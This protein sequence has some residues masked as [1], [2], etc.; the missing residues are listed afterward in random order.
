[1]AP[2]TLRTEAG[3]AAR[4]HG[5]GGHARAAA[6][7]PTAVRRRR[8][9]WRSSPLAR[10]RRRRD[11]RRRRVPRARCG[12]RTAPATVALRLAAGR[13]TSP[14]TLRLA[15]PR[16]LGPAVARLRRLLDLDAD[17]VAVDE[18]ARAP[19]RRWPRPSPRCRAS[20]C[21][22][23]ST[24]SRRRCARVLGPAGVGR[25]GPHGGRAAGRGAGRAAAR[26]RSPA[27]GR[28]PAVPD[29]RR[30]SPSTAPRCSPA[31][32][33]GSRARARLGRGA[34][35][36]HAARSTPAAT[37]PTCAPSWSRCPASGR[38]P[39]ATSRC[40]CSATPTSCWP[41]DLARAPRRRRPRPAVRR[42][43]P[44]PRAAR[45]RPGGPSRHPPVAR[46]HAATH[47]WR[48]A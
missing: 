38:G 23:R 13:A 25:G 9:C 34:R 24:A 6:A 21:R 17:P 20:G 15:D 37:P 32:P 45:W 31:R 12:C 48:S 10:R 1:M 41:N 16:D 22:A 46:R 33:G 27:T 4:R 3:R 42:R 8:A 26:P 28:R 2:T 5:G 44:D 19:T 35:R 14:A 7:V 43:R 29:A 40:A 47:L 39:P 36:R 30:R 11:A 18:R